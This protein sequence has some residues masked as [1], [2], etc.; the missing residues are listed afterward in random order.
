MEIQWEKW[1][2]SRWPKKEQQKI[3]TFSKKSYPLE[4]E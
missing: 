2:A 3:E 1:Q 4:F